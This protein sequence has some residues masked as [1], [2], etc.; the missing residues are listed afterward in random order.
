M[1]SKQYSYLKT[2]ASQF[3]KEK[4]AR[5]PAAKAM[6]EAALIAQ[7]PGPTEPRKHLFEQLNVS[8]ELFYEKYL[9]PWSNLTQEQ[10]IELVK[11]WNLVNCP[12]KNLLLQ[13]IPTYEHLALHWTL[14]NIYETKLF[15]VFLKEYQTELPATCPE[16][17]D[18]ISYK[19]GG[20]AYAL[21][22][23]QCYYC[24]RLETDP[25]GREFGKQGL[26]YCHLTECS[27][28]P[29][30][31]AHA[32]GCCYGDWKRQ[33]NNIRNI[34]KRQQTD[35]NKVIAAFLSFCEA[36]YQANL[37]MRVRVQVKQEKPYDW[38]HYDDYLGSIPYKYQIEIKQAN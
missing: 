21:P 7:L 37:Q 23:K 31:S 3:L 24:G 25:R 38:I 15:D 16:K 9:T 34:C 33:K 4:A 8:T 36:R 18:W 13:A 2:V 10:V 17:L 5:N 22:F 12:E 29:S 11:H 6:K 1:N 30:P 20:P 35:P 26:F 27:P 14:I 28:E 32:F 19:F